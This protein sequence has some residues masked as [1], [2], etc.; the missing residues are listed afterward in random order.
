M[1]KRSSTEGLRK[2]EEKKKEPTLQQRQQLPGQ[3][4]Y[5][6]SHDTEQSQKVAA[7]QHSGPRVNYGV[8]TPSP[9]GGSSARPNPSGQKD[10]QT[11]KE[12]VPSVSVLLS[13]LPTTSVDDL[14]Q[15][16]RAAAALMDEMVKEVPVD[17]DGT[18]V[19]GQLDD[20]LEPEE[21]LLPGPSG[22][23]LRYVLECWATYR[24]QISHQ[25]D[26]FDHFIAIKLPEIIAEGS[27]VRIDNEKRGVS[28]TIEFGNVLVRPPAIR[29]SD[30][31]YRR[32]TPQECR[33]RGLSYTVGVYVDVMHTISGADG[34]SCKLYAE[35]PLCRIPCMVRSSSCTLTANSRLAR[36]SK[37]CPLDP[38]G[39]FIVNGNEK[40]IIAQ[41]K[42]RTNY[43]FVRRLAA[44]HCT[45]EIRSLHEA[46]TRST[47]TLVV[48]LGPRAGA[49]GETVTVALPFVDVPVPCGVIFRLLGVESP[50]DAIRDTISQLP[51]EHLSHKSEIADTLA[52]VL[53][54]PMASEQ[55]VHLIEW[56]GREGTKEPTPQ[57]RARYVEHILANEFLPHMGLDASTE[58]KARKQAFLSLVVLKLVLVFL[59]T[60]EQDDRDDYSLKRIDTTGMLFGLLFRQLFRSFHK[61]LSM[62]V[63]RAVDGAKYVNI[64]E[65]L[66]PKK[67]TAGFKFALNTGNWGIQRQTNTQNGVAQ[68][69]ARMNLLAHVSHLRRVCTP[70]NREGKLPKPRELPL[71]HHGILC[72]V[73]TPEGQ[74]CGLV[75]NLSLLCHVRTGASASYVVG[76]LMREN[77]IRPLTGAGLEPHTWRVLVNG[78]L[79]GSCRDGE[80]LAQEL[81][82]RRGAGVLPF[83]TSISTCRSSASVIVDL[84]P[85]CL[86]RPLLR[87]D[88]MDDFSAVVRRCPPVLLWKELVFQGI[89]EFIDKNEERNLRVGALDGGRRATH[90]E[91][92]PSAMLGVCALSIPFLNCNQAPRNIYEAAMTKQS[93]GVASL[94]GEHRVDAV[95]HVLHYPHVPLVR[96]LLHEALR[97]DEAPCGCNAMVAILSYSGFN[98]EDSII[99]S[100]GALDRGLFRSTVFKSYKDEEK[101]VGSDIESFGPVPST[102]VGA[103]RADYGKVQQDGLPALRSVVQNG[104][105]IISKCMMASQLGTDRK[106]RKTIAV[107]H[108]T[109]LCATE[110]MRVGRAY[111]TTNK[112]GARLVRVRLHT[113]RVPDVGDKLSSHHGQKGVI[114]M[115]LEQAD[116][117][118][119]IDG[120]VPDIIINPHAIPSRMTVAQLIESLLGKVCCAVGAEGDG[121]PFNGTRVE[122]IAEQLAAVGFE[123]RGNERMFNGITGEPL[124]TTVFFGPTAYQ[125]LRHCVADKV[126]ARARGSMT[127]ITR[128]P[129]EGRSRGGGLRVGEME[130]DCMLSHG[131]SAV[132]LDRLMHQ[133]DEFEMRVCRHCGL[134]A[135]SLSPLAPLG[136]GGHRDYCRNCKLG[137]SENIAVVAIPYA[138]KLLHQELGGLNIAMRF[139]VASAGERRDV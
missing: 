65:A 80:A 49:R 64:V 120:V 113:T 21:D 40:A 26:S 14:S 2:D 46:K 83:D 90:F 123:S 18:S 16:S 43:V 59:G 94:A 129:R 86:M 32:L 52:K 42:L 41:E 30:G 17:D 10:C 108:S 62:H 105:V 106:K 111:L 55:P 63:H 92:H 8:C 115:I 116:M 19:D 101:G 136:V 66:N 134:L 138:A 85:G 31:V 22:P 56:I 12:N 127:L 53:E 33:I 118:Y 132:L 102:A 69:M 96:T 57:R 126:H 103:R 37:E 117:P 1:R 25:L 51:E 139:R 131:A 20:T 137:G 13:P 9:L 4:C 34:D 76:Q 88:R 50:E 84:D 109:V 7:L 125:K 107:D 133:S 68:L 23:E 27:V 5:T 60:I 112:D 81:R 48:T 128:Q 104:D 67:I 124:E 100:R 114:G 98:Q 93:S 87:A 38:G 71:S 79:E 72:P 44:R 24:G 15:H 89:V 135:E 70:I 82:W 35:T 77:L 110:P 122:T 78:A 99:V 95:S 91:F 39:Y 119:T 3:S 36:R 74:A 130:R 11:L 6:S 97:C 61:M 58:T 29:E 121:T 47:S 73:E 28:H 75:E 45:A 54:T